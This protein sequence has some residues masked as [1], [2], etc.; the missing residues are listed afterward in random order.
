MNKILKPYLHDFMLVFFDDI[1]IYSKTWV[2][3]VHQVDK[4]LQLPWDHELFIKH[5][6]WSI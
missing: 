5:P 1:M 3:H 4:A 2:A 6:K